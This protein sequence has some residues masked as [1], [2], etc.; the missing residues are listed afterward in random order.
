MKPA[1]FEYSRPASLGEQER[2]IARQRAEGVPWEEIARQ[3]REGADTLRKR[4]QRAV[5]RAVE[6]IEGRWSESG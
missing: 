6:Q 4:Y 1:P 5:R 2:Q 3:V